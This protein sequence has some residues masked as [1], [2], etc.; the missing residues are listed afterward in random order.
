[1]RDVDFLK[2]QAVAHSETIGLMAD[3]LLQ[4]PLPWTR[5]RQVYAL[6]GLV[7]RYGVERVEPECARALRESMHSVRR[8]ERMVKL[9]AP[10]EPA[11]AG[12]VIPLGRYLRPAN[13]YALKRKK[14]EEL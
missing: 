6:L 3:A 11:P 5:M 12:K 1:M 13:Q 14:K 7:R 2:R 10:P 4:G 9:N 8:L